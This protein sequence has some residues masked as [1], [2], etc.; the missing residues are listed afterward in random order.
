VSTLALTEAPASARTWPLPVAWIA[1]AIGAGIALVLR[2]VSVDAFVWW[3]TA[4]FAALC[5]RSFLRREGLDAGDVLLLFTLY[6]AMA[7][8]LRGIG[9][10]SWVD[11]PYLEELGDART[12]HFRMLVG[13]S[14]FYSALGL[15]AVQEGYRSPVALRWADAALRRLPGL[16][17]PWRTSRV[18][19]V[20]VA[21]VVLGVSGAV[22]RVGSLGGFMRAAS[23]PIS[24]GTEDALGHWWQI[25]LTEF[26]VVGFH[27]HITRLLMRNDRHWLKHYLV[28]GLGLCGPIYLISSSK[29]LLLRTLFTPWL[30]RHFLQR[31]VALWQLLA[32]FAG[33]SALF[34]LFYAYRAVGLENLDAIGLYLQN[35][36]TKAPLEHVFNRAYGTDSFML[37]LH[38]TGVTLPFQWGASLADLGTFWIPRVLWAGKPDS[39]GLQFPALYM[40]DMHWGAMT[41]VTTSL[42]GELYLNFHVAGVLVGSWLLGAA[43]RTTRALAFAG[44]GGVL[45]YC[46]AFITAMHL[47]EGCIASQLE[48]FLTDLLPALLAIAVLTLAVRRRA[49]A[50]A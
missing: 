15:F 34:P 14:Q 23:S 2:E 21:L 4:G 44:P 25:A 49:G 39:F 1:V 40:P 28:F 24:T 31:R 29:F 42:P 16:G 48:T 17:R 43:M 12:A 38:R 8:L 5:A 36:D 26:A 22:G 18:T 19:L 3:S 6:Y 27:V 20:A 41:Y 11:S 33:F 37:I 47:A 35:T 7:L 30:L 46:Y 9:V 10:M 13:W 45:V 32:A 50:P